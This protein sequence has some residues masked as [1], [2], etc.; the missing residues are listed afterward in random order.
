MRASPTRPLCGD[1]P[2]SL[3]VACTRPRG[4]RGKHRHDTDDA[5][6]EWEAHIDRADRLRDELR[7]ALTQLQYHEDARDHDR[8]RQLQERE[9]LT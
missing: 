2:A 7:F 4:H 1:Q 8:I 6:M 3:K 9:G 5:F